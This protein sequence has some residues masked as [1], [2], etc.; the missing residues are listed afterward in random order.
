MSSNQKFIVTFKD[1]VS[2]D[3]IKKYVEQVNGSGG[4]VY[5]NYDGV[6]TGFAAEIP[7][8]TLQAFQKQQSLTD[9]IIQGI[10]PDGEVHIN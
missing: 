4:K 2:Q 8:Q 10:E 7:P 3:E 6:I 1:G 9:S 5:H